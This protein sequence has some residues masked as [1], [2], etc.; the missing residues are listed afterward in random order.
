MTKRPPDILVEAS[1]P[2]HYV[3]LRCGCGAVIYAHP[4]RQAPKAYSTNTGSLKNDV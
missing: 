4:L 2:A 1:I 3:R